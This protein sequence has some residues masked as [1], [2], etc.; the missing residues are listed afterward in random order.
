MNRPEK[1]GEPSLDDILATMRQGFGDEPAVGNSV[2]PR[3]TPPQTPFGGLAP[4]G[5]VQ[6]AASL[7][8]GHS[9]T[10]LE[11]LSGS[12]AGA[13]RPQTGLGALSS[14]RPSPIDDDLADLLD[15]APP[16]QPPLPTRPSLSISPEL[17]VYE[18]NG[19]SAGY[20][21][22]P[23]L[24]PSGSMFAGTA[25]PALEGAALERGVLERAV[26]Q[27]SLPTLPLPPAP[28]V[29]A[30]SVS[31]AAVVPPSLPSLPPL[32]KPGFMPPLSAYEKAPTTSPPAP[33]LGEATDIRT[34]SGDDI[35]Q[36]LN[37]LSGRAPR[38]PRSEDAAL[39]E[40]VA[41]VAVAEPLPPVASFIPD[42]IAVETQPQPVVAESAAYSAPALSEEGP[43]ALVTTTTEVLD[44]ITVFSA[45]A[46]AVPSIA[47]SALDA[48]AIGL[49]AA[50]SA[51]P[52]EGVVVS[53]PDII[54]TSALS[55][56]QG[57]APPEARGELVGS[58]SLP[59]PPVPQA[60]PQAPAVRTLEDAVAEM[61]RPML[62][63]WIADHMPRILE[64]VL[65]DDFVKGS[66]GKSP[67]G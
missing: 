40:P 65:R 57:E 25:Q 8:P 48:L 36:A 23:P 49:A 38:T 55:E 27:A 5:S 53:P 26:P 59:A 24:P 11:R 43:A 66:A 21:A 3:P 46:D 39:T 63:Q 1:V 44:E 41:A 2:A 50:A 45:E 13:P 34:I 15:D 58:A 61:L 42:P 6:Q 64:K 60:A 22:P 10:L 51:T 19:F 52:V 37:V 12:L 33:S 17:P 7:P 31:P 35:E 62:Q 67:G 29:S 14:K 28:S 4:L 9:G 18:P 20:P 30:S 56:P 47:T 54:E 16:R 32:R